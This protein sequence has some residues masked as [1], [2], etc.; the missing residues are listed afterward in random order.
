MTPA[1]RRWAVAAGVPCALAV[2]LAL[3]VAPV[4]AV[5]G[6]IQRL[7][8]LHVPA[9]W[10]AYLCF[11]AVLLASAR[12][13]RRRT[14]RSDRLARAAAEVG[15]VLTAV[16]LATGSIWG[17][18]TWGTWWVW[19]ARVTTTVAMGLVY[20]AYLALRGATTTRTPAAVVGVAGFTVV[21]VVH[22]SVLW[23]RSLHQPPTVLAP[24]L[25]PPLDPLMGLA[26]AV[27]VAALTVV[28]AWVVSARTAA[29]SRADA[30]AAVPADARELTGAPR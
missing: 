8:Y 18:G 19:D 3:V 7:M 6:P 13:L 24:D 20:V 17:A 27:A 4:D 10:C 11:F 14:S 2:L 21:P 30:A 16:T 9:A 23:W 5:Q 25:T 12:H 28:T 22:F 26:L 1:S 29:L 15:V